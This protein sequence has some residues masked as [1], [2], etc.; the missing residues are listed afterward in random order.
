V[1]ART[2]AFTAIVF[3]EFFL[4]YNCRSETNSVLKLGWKGL[5]ANKMLFYSILTSI[6]LQVAIVYV[7]FLHPIFDTTALSPLELAICS[8]GAL[9]GLLLFP[10]KLIK[11]QKNQ[12]DLTDELSNC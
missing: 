5:T 3:F 8:L 11:K 1:K 2:M 12:S 10:G 6:L 4:A 9:S 7:P